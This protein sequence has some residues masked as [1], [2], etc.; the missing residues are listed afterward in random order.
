M[1]VIEIHNG[2]EIRF[3]AHSGL[4]LSTMKESSQFWQN[5]HLCKDS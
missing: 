2:I 4:E 3:I 5:P 1:Q